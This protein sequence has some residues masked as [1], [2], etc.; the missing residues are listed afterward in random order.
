MVDL[1]QFNNFGDLVVRRL[2][3][4]DAAAALGAYDLDEWDDAP[5]HAVT[6]APAR[7]AEEISS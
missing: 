3:A 7:D 5:T 4:N 6:P 1:V 2:Q